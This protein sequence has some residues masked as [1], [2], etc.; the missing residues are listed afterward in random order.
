M[1]DF[2]HSQGVVVDKLKPILAHKFWILFGLAL[3]VPLVGWWLDTSSLAEQTKARK[4]KVNSAFTAATV[5]GAVPNDDWKK[6]LDEINVEQE[7]R[8]K[9]SAGDLYKRQKEL[10]V[11]PA[12]IAELMKDVPYQGEIADVARRVYRTSYFYALRDVRSVVQPYD[13][14]TGTGLVDF[15]E[16]ALK[17]VPDKAWA[18]DPPTSKAMWEAQEDLIHWKELLRAVA[19]VNGD[20]KSMADNPAIR[21][22]HKLDLLGGSRKGAG[23]AAPA[24]ST[25]GAADGAAPPAAGGGNP[26]GLL[27]G[28]GGQQG[29][30]RA[31]SADF[32]IAEELSAA[33][34]GGSAEGGAPPPSDSP[35]TGGAGD[36]A[37]REAARYVD[38][39]PNLPYRVRFFY[40]KVTMDHQKVP[41]LLAALTNLRYP[42]TVVRVQQAAKFDDSGAS[43]GG[44]AGEGMGGR[45]P[46]GVPMGN[47][48]GGG[49]EDPKKAAR[50][51]AQKVFQNAMND[52]YLA[53]VVVAGL[54]TLYQPPK[55]DGTAGA[56]AASPEAEEPNATPMPPADGT[57]PPA[58]P[59]APT[60]PGTAPATPAVPGNPTTPAGTVPP[61][62]ASKAPAT[63]GTDPKPTSPPAEKSESPAAAPD[64][65]AKPESAKPEPPKPEAPA[66]AT[67]APG[68]ATAPK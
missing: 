2:Q 62:D 21:V 15:P 22:I 46:I 19:A 42:V 20:A 13:P 12:D 29:G 47:P 30:G 66:P 36:S 58:D 57:T 63:P 45:R 38:E 59:T 44:D 11:W 39:D 53:E 17:S 26:F 8:L 50:D 1:V 68:G 18:G 37:P 27:V 52:P 10:M 16:S 35:A 32:P 14:A 6:K 41:D 23:A 54:M 49:E 9:E 3:L 7:K 4:D 24:A 61:A 48:G 56:P 31:G 33:A 28:G 40:L 65:S 43:R 34:G 64:A 60:T 51:A 67:P 5:N 55:D 25:E